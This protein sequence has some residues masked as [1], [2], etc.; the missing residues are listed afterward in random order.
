[1]SKNQVW[2]LVDR[3]K[4]SL[5]GKRPNI[6]DSRWVLKRKSDQH[7]EKKYRARLEIRGFK[8]GNLYD[9]SET[10]APISR[11]PLVTSVIATENSYDLQMCQLDVKTAFL[12]G[13]LDEGIYMESPDCITSVNC[14]RK[15]KVGKLKT[16]TVR[17][18]N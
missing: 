18:E 1:M 17:F 13:L 16:G 12:N 14:K 3:P 11:L 2:K 8:D 10:Y 15:N 9:L 6:I 7:G 4:I 5:T